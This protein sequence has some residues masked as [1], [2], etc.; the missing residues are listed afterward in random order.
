MS[1]SSHITVSDG[2]VVEL[3]DEIEP[4]EIETEPE[5]ETNFE[6]DPDQEDY[7]EFENQLGLPEYRDQY[8]GIYA[9]SPPPVD[10]NV[11]CDKL[12]NEESEFFLNKFEPPKADFS[13]SQSSLQNSSQ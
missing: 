13:V 8:Y 12:N 4:A 2:S 3:Q 11:N 9:S 10:A 5:I 7:I 6:S 1:S